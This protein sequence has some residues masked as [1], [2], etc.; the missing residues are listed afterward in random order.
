LA[1]ETQALITGSGKEIKCPRTPARSPAGGK[2]IIKGPH[3]PPI[4]KYGRIAFWFLVLSLWP[5]TAALPQN[6]QTYTSQKYG[7]S[8]QYPASYQLKVSP[9]GYFDFMKGGKYQFSLQV[10][11]NFIDLLYQMVHPG[12]IVFRIGE[13][14]YRELARETRKNPELFRRYAR[15]QARYWCSADGPDGSEYCQSF[16]SEKSFA[17]R[18]GLDC[19][20][21]YPLMT[22]ED[23]TDNSKEVHL[24]GPVFAVYLPKGDLPLVRANLPVGVAVTPGLIQENVPLLLLFSPRPEELASPALVQEIRETIDSLKTLQ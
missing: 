1:D 12:P 8:F 24:V 7:F 17:S 4:N 3:N 2:G 22:R 23:Y 9:G 6:K 11:D 5:L 18:G 15:N 10:D 14:P 20:E 21:F 13:D 16:Q 19:L